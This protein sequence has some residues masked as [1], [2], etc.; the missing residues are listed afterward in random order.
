MISR[1]SHYLREWGRR[2]LAAADAV[3]NRLYTW[4]YNP[5]YHS[6]T[7]VVLAF[8]LMLATGVYLLFFYR[9][10]SP[11]ESMVRINEQVWAG[12]WM[13]ALHRYAADLAIVA[14]LLHAFRI[15]VQGRSWGPRTLAWVSGVILFFLTFAS[16]WTGYVMLW[17]DQA[18]L[19]AV[20]GARLLDAL[21]IFS[22]PISRTF[23]GDR[24]IPGAFFF[25]NLFLHIALPVGVALILW[26]HVSRQSRPSLLPPRGLLWGTTLLLFAASVIGPAPLGPKADLY[27]VLGTVDVDW[28]YAF[29]VPMSR[30]LQPVDAWLAFLAFGALLCLVPWWSRPVAAEMPEPS[31]S[32]GRLC[33]GCNQCSIDCPYEA[34]AMVRLVDDDATREVAEVNEDYCVSCG[35]CSA[36][37]APMVV[38]P[39]ER[40]GRDEL[41]EIR[42]F[43]AEQSIGP[44]DVVL[45]ACARGAGRLAGQ[46]EVQGARIFPVICI[47]NL[48]TSVVEFLLRAGSGGV[49]IASCPPR[50]CWSREG[51][52]WLEERLYHG[53]EA[54]LRESVDR[55]RIRVVYAGEGERRVVLGALAEFRRDVA[56]LDNTVGEDGIEIDTECDRDPRQAS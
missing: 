15:F 2:P 25:L 33:T 24:P 39:P 32:P 5:L 31:R 14:G 9:I 11:Y 43:I 46:A 13:R 16:G 49:L 56:E 51:P 1:A 40:T 20:E 7:L 26:I 27:R 47:G 54:E 28:F 19:L 36:S 53:R 44:K 55:R 35:I 17:D 34:I 8:L 3:L 12:R 10:G 22:E 18:Q 38:G 52:R 23:V 37:C 6:G 29:F 42:A 50:D 4:R 48:H 45:I 30:L 41:T 21:P